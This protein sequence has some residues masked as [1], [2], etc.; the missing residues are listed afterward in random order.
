MTFPLPKQSRTV[1]DFQCPAKAET[2]HW[3][4]PRIQATLHQNASMNLMRAAEGSPSKPAKPSNG[5]G[6]FGG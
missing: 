1:L 4:Q 3:L 5:Y 2:S 6:D